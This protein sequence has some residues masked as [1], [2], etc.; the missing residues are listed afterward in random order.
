M[1]VSLIGMNCTLMCQYIEFVA[2][3]LLV[4]LGCE[5]VSYLIIRVKRNPGSVLKSPP[6]ACNLLVEF[7]C[8]SLVYTAR[9][10]I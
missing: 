8:E 9:S 2:D 4:E 10:R 6:G 5:K 3:C 7:E 1:P